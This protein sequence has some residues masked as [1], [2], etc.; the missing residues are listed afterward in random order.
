MKKSLATRCHAGRVSRVRRLP[1]RSC[2]GT[3][4]YR[5]TEYLSPLTLD[6]CPKISLVFVEGFFRQK[7]LSAR[8]SWTGIRPWLGRRLLCWRRRASRRRNHQAGVG[9]RG[10]L[11]SIQFLPCSKGTGPGAP[12]SSYPRN[13]RRRQEHPH[14][15][16]SNAPTTEHCG[17][18][19]S[20]GIGCAGSGARDIHNRR[21]F[22]SRN[23]ANYNLL[24]VTSKLLPPQP[25]GQTCLSYLHHAHSSKLPRR[26]R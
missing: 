25:H 16:R 22:C 9:G 14:T 15:G 6:A 12:G 5:R 21:D 24:A 18:P 23:R 11:E 17:V 3:R 26:Q 7:S 8:V 10:R 19:R 4:E 20:K 13:L 2:Y 1:L